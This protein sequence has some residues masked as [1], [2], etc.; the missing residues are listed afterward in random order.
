KRAAAAGCVRPDPIR[1]GSRNRSPR[2]AARRARHLRREQ[3]KAFGRVED[4]GLDV[5][6]DLGFL[7]ELAHRAG[8][9]DPVQHLMLARI[10]HLLLCQLAPIAEA[11]AAQ[12]LEAR[13]IGDDIRVEPAMLLRQRAMRPARRA[14]QRDAPRRIG[15]VARRRAAELEAARRARRWRR[16]LVRALAHHAGAGLDQLAAIAIHV[17]GNDRIVEAEAL[18]LVIEI[19]HGVVEGMREPAGMAHL[20][21]IGNIEA[22][23]DQRLRQAARAFRVASDRQLGILRQSPD[24]LIG[25]EDSKTAA[26]GLAD[27]LVVDAD[28]ESGNAVALEILVLIIAPDEDDIGLERIEF[29]AQPRITGDQPIAML[30]RRADAIVIAPFAAHGLGPAVA[31]GEIL[32]FHATKLDPA[33]QHAR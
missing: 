29:L 6:D 13:A 22:A 16:N 11:I 32:G 2:S 10:L 21:R 23:F 30:A 20:L 33:L 1:L 28:A 19:D 24:I 12:L 14:D 26:I 5:I 25:L 18:L 4:V 7:A 9:A 15:K 27:D 3:R 31:R 8:E 17:E